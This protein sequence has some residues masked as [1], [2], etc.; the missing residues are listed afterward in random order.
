MVI[1]QRSKG[2]SE[3]TAIRISHQRSTFLAQRIAIIVRQ[4]GLLHS[5]ALSEMLGVQQ[6]YKAV[7]RLRSF[8]HSNSFLT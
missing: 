2:V 8:P 3:S 4:A 6:R 7:G 5:W 1:T